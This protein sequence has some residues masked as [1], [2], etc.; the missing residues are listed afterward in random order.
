[1]IRIWQGD[2]CTRTEYY[3]FMSE[4]AEMT[5]QAIKHTPRGIPTGKREGRERREREREREEREGREREERE[6]IEEREREER[7]QN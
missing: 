5:P 6:K 1:M 4:A 7:E 2:V 3:Q